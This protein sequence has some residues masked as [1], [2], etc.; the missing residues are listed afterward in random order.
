MVDLDGL[1]ESLVVDNDQAINL[2][3]AS[4]A[5]WGVDLKCLV[6]R[7]I[8]FHPARSSAC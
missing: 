5:D 1:L 3:E 4:D 2:T 8:P 6:V 7:L